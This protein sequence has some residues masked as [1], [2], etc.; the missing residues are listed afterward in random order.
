MGKITPPARIQRLSPGLA[1]QIAA[2]EVVE[3]P[4]SVVKE[5]L[6]NSLDS[7]AKN[8]VIEVEEGGV[9]LIRVRDDGD[10]IHQDDLVLAVTSHSTSKIQS[11][12]DLE[13]ITSLGFRGEALPS[14]ASISR[15]TMISRTAD[16][17]Q[18]WSL[19]T[20]G[21]DSV[22]EPAPFAHPRGTTIEVRDLFFNTPAR[23]KFLRTEKTELGHLLEVVKR[24]ALSRFDIGIE[25]K[26]NRRSFLHL[27]PAAAE[28]R[29]GKRVA[30]VCGTAFMEQ[31]LPVDY[32]AGDMRILGWLGTPDISRGHADLQYFYLNGRIIRDKLVTHAVRQAYG[33]TLYPGRFPAYV[34]YL[35]TDPAQ[36]DVNVHPTKH[37]VR[38][39]EARL[40][41]DF[42]LHGLERVLKGVVPEGGIPDGAEV[43]TVSSVVCSAGAGSHPVAGVPRAPRQNVREAVARYH[44]LTRTP[45]TGGIETKPPPGEEADG[46]MGRALAQFKGRYM[47]SE[48][49]DGLVVVDI[50][51]VR[52]RTIHERLRKDL[53]SGPLRPQPLLLPVS[54]NMGERLVAVVEE[55]S[56]LLGRLG[57]EFTRSGVESISLRQVPTLLRNAEPLD[58]ARGLLELLS[59]NS[60]D[61]HA[62]MDEVL[63]TL[64]LHGAAASGHHLSPAEMDSLLRDIGRLK[65]D[66]HPPTWVRISM[67]ELERMFR[68]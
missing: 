46:P 18:G 52:Q 8:I 55:Q 23:R 24:I 51:A 36:T 43:S 53:D 26:H 4:A 59:G 48:D 62:N 10:G 66:S 27:R 54:L 19:S 45:G 44:A 3:R 32:Q 21:R 65:D 41:H 35:E 34:L 67:E 6:E 16:A 49:E 61:G 17:E 58:L 50:P 37:E 63:S 7:G 1:N 60:G 39:H 29:Q 30:A 2:G 11:L 28:N 22:A 64:A 9:R 38:F 56:D 33:E 31:A 25:F 15:M 12:D 13:H 40:V 5:L 42:I 68:K 57:F 47:L 20:E 14:I